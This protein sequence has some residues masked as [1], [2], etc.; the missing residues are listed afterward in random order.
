LEFWIYITII[1]GS[2]ILPFIKGD[3]P[4]FKF[5]KKKDDTPELLKQ[6]S[7]FESKPVIYNKRRDKKFSLVMDGN[8]LIIKD[9]KLNQLFTVDSVHILNGLYFVFYTPHAIYG[10]KCRYPNEFLAESNMKV[11]QIMPVATLTTNEKYIIMEC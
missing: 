6:L 2:F 7:V 8:N 1:T 4:M 9:K 3:S 10:Y 5:L 11:R